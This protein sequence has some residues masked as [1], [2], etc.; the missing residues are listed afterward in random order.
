MEC[1]NDAE[2]P[3]GLF[4]VEVEPSD[5]VHSNHKDEVYLRVG[6]ENRRLTFLQRQELLYDKGQASY[7]VT[8]LADASVEDLDRELLASYAAAV[9]HPDPVRLLRARG[10]IDRTDNL[11]IAGVLLFAEHPQR[12]LPEA[13]IRILR[14]RGTERGTGARQQLLEDV[15]IDG[16]I[17]LQ[18]S[19]GREA[20]FRLL[21]TRRAL[22]RT[23]RFERIGLI[24]RDAWLEGLVNAAIHRS[25][26]IS[27]DHIRIEI[28]DDRIEVESPG[29]FPGISDI[30]NPLKVTRFAR[31]PRIARV[32]AD[33]AFGQELGEGI[34]R[35]FEEM[36]LAGLA[37]P[38]YRQTSGSVRLVLD[39]T[40]ID[41]ELES[42][43][44]PGPGT[45]SPSSGRRAGS[46]PEISSRPAG[47]R[48]PWS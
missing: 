21:P 34:R 36:R 25:Y 47:L 41:V 15:R 33:L 46:A 18:L 19:A 48:G 45:S 6:D 9:N 27:G 2:E 26:S 42:R 1:L 23:G 31:N 12:W 13:N 35:I 14:Y 43:L 40:P 17:P 32:C 10:L 37:D 39:S 38:E 3:D 24:P 8:P 20:V 5:R 29:R 11:T 22:A 30:S 16:S 4:V 44:P 28:F 7:E